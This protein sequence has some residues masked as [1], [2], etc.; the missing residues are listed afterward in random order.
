MLPKISNVT[1]K[2]VGT[3][4]VTIIF[5]TN[6]PASGKVNY[7]TTTSYTNTDGGHEVLL[8]KHS[9][10]LSGLKPDTNYNFVMVARDTYGNESISGN[11]TFKTLADSFSSAAE[12]AQNET[13]SIAANEPVTDQT[14]IAPAQGGSGGHHSFTPTRTLKAPELIKVEGLDGMVLF[15]WNPKQPPKTKPGSTQIRTNMV[16][17]R[18]LIRPSDNPTSGEII[19]KGNSG[20]F[21]DV[22]LENG[23]T[24]HYSVFTINQF[25]S[26]SRPT[27]SAVVPSRGDREMELEAV[28]P[29]VQKNPIYVFP[30]ELRRGDTNKHVEHLQ[31]L[32]ASEP[33]LYKKGFITGYFGPLTESAVK[34]FQKRYKL[35]PTGVA[36]AVTLKE[37]EKLSSIEVV[38][39]RA[40]VYANALTRDLGLGSRGGDVSVLQQFLVGVG[41]Y[42]EAVVS[43]YFGS[44]TKVALQKFQKEQNIAPISG[45][46]G[47]MTKKRILNLIRLRGVSF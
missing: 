33:S 30:Q 41:V 10:P 23:K 16:I 37:L 1:I 8:T 25:N 31:V 7:A 20:F 13:N 4:S 34:V 3:S 18:N 28:S 9:H 22:G 32:L 46:F 29:V 44:L 24:H 38:N 40:T 6:V 39:D 27:R 42:P 36:D 11:K 17:V 14:T 43:G 45:Y 21:T 12:N 26:Y 47:P 19:Y 5:D 2:S 15:R 35:Q